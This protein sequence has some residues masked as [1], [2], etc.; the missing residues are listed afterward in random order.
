MDVFSHATAGACTGLAFGR[1]VLGAAIAAAPDLMLLGKRVAR[2][3]A[4]YNFTHSLLFLGLATALGM[5]FDSGLFVAAVLLSHLV[6]D[7]PTHGEQWAPPLLYP[8]RKTRFSMGEEWEFFN[9]PW[10]IGFLITLTWCE[11]WLLLSSRSDIGFLLSL[12]VLLI[13]GLTS[14]SSR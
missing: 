7:L 5:L 13:L 14:S 1:P 6:L 4:L 10:I 12:A 9:V 3:P 2:P 11:I 8:F